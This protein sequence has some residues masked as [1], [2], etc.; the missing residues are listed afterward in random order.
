MH[1]PLPLS[2]GVARRVVD[3]ALLTWGG[4]WAEDS[5]RE[6]ALL[7][8]SAGIRRGYLK[9]RLTVAEGDAG[10]VVS[11]ETKERHLEVNRAAAGVL[12]LGAFGGVLAVLW[13]FYPELLRLAP[14]GAVLAVVAWLMVAGRLRGRGAE[15]FLDLVEAMASQ[16]ADEPSPTA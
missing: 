6:I 16:A 9:G 14:I 11:L 4:E 15:E 2:L 13:P 12:A 10:A 7:P 3:D 1:R 5:N 8:I